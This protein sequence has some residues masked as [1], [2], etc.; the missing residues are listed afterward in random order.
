LKLESLGYSSFFDEAFRTVAGEGLVPGRVIAGHTHVYRVATDAEEV[1]GEVSGRLRHEA[2]GPEDFPAVG[3]WVGVAPWPGERK[4]TIH[5]VLPRRTAFV[6]RAAGGRDELQ[7][8]AAN[9]DTVFLVAGLDGDFNPRRVERALVL[10]WDSGAEPVVVLNKAD[11]ST[12]VAKRRRDM[13]VAAAG[14]PVLVV[15]AREGTGLDALEPHLAPGRTIALLGSSGVGKSTLANRL[16]GGERIRT[17]AV[18]EHDQRGRHTTTHREIL[19]LPGGALLLDTPG[20]REIQLWA[21]EDAISSAFSDVAALAAG[22]RFRDCRHQGEPGCAVAAA[23]VSGSLAEERLAS[24]HKLER[25]VEHHRVRE[26]VGLQRAQ[27]AK[28]KAIHKA[29]RKH[30][31][32]E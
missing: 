27:K 16:L 2:H 10:A 25:E 8:L 17:S 32:R 6:R 29:A 4:A 12:D 9:V 5:L 7:V 28:W 21:G 11:L 18:R 24:H 30:R 1:L 31:P 13:Q 20:L 22:C 15:S 26:D 23:V 19:A 3:D 14:V